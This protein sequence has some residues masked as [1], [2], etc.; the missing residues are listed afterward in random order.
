[1]ADVAHRD[2]FASAA[3]RPFSNVNSKNVVA[4]SDSIDAAQSSVL[5]DQVVHSYHHRNYFST[6]ETRIRRR[7]LFYGHRCLWVT[8]LTPDTCAWTKVEL[9]RSKLHRCP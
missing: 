3:D 2:E 7:L 9:G 5:S 6:P 1:M 4:T 8:S